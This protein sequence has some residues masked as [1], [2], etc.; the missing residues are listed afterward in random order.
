MYC[1][2]GPVPWQ[3][4]ALNLTKDLEVGSWEERMVGQCRSRLAFKPVKA[5][6]V[7]FYSQLPDGAC[8]GFV[9]DGDL[10]ARGPG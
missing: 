7:L 1:P 8:C 4:R 3:A 5:K 10:E 9:P 6:S 2:L